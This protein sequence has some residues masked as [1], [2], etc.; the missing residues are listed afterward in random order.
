MNDIIIYVL[1]P[2]F[3]AVSFIYSSVGFAGGSSYIA[4]LILAGISLYTAPSIAL[5]LNIFAASMAFINYARAGHL[6]LKFSLP[7][8]SSIPFA[9]YSGLL[10]LPEKSLVL[11]FIITLFAASA[12]LLTSGGMIKNQRNKII[13]E[14][15]LDKV[16]IVIIGIPVGVA[17][18]ILAGLVGIGGGIWLSPLL[19]LTGL[20]DPKRAAA[21]ASLFILVNSVSGLLAHSISKEFDLSLLVPLALVVIAGGFIGSRFG[22]FRFD[23]D[24]I[25]IIVGLLV[26]YSLS[27][28][29]TSNSGIHLTSY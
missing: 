27:S 2:L 24:K 1:A 21:T 29:S 14:I 26:A 25:R 6:S 19:I 7:F 3:F 23:H 28:N 15:N 4:I 5:T 17:L 22:A 20:A 11:V 8:L 16:K 10:V 9:F 13:R 18:G 12:A